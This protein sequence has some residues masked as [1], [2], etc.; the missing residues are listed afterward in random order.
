MLV[1]AAAWIVLI[2]VSFFIGSA[3]MSLSDLSSFPLV[4][5]RFVLATWMG[6]ITLA[7]GLMTVSLAL[8]LV[9]TVTALT[10]L[11]L[12][13]GA[14]LVPKARRTLREAIQSVRP[15]SVLG[16]T[17]LLLGTAFYTSQE[18]TWSDT[19]LY[20]AGAIA[21]LSQSGT[22]RGIALLEFRYGFTSAWFSLAAAFNTGPLYGRMEAL[23]GGYALLLAS[24]HFV[25]SAGRIAAGHSRLPDWFAATA[26]LTCL[27]WLVRLGLSISPSPDVPVIIVVIVVT[28]SILSLSTDEAK[29]LPE[30]PSRLFP[31]HAVPVLMAAGA[32]SLKPTAAPLLLVAVLFYVWSC[33]LT[34]QFVAL[35][36]LAALL[37]L[38]TLVVSLTTSGCPLFPSP[39]LCTHLPWSLGSQVAATDQTDG[40][41]FLRW[42]GPPPSYGD[43]FNW[44]GHWARSE[45]LGTLYIAYML[46]SS[47]VVAVVARF[48]RI[49]GAPWLIL[50]GLAG[51]A[52]VL[53]LSPTYRFLLGYV[54]VPPAYLAALL[55]TRFKLHPVV[56]VL[57][58]LV[59]I[60]SFV[61]VTVVDQ[62]SNAWT[63]SAVAYAAILPAGAL[64]LGVALLLPS[65]RSRSNHGA[66][67]RPWLAYAVCGIVVG[68]MFMTANRSS[69]SSVALLSPPTLH[70]PPK[71]ALIEHS[72]ND[73][74]YVSPPSDELCWA[75]IPCTVEPMPPDLH[76]LNPQQGISG[77]LAKR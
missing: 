8:P 11:A 20:H 28:W 77:G 50:I 5:D 12:L 70:S 15:W 52:Y 35:A 31:P 37:V 29:H 22:V 53:A 24:M 69:P 33:R 3:V 21:W 40:R 13:I 32:F 49:R 25:V 7:I 14:A 72:V 54:I 41:D 30:R 60:V 63:R 51:V 36:G 2:A 1:L 34:L 48:I 59:A 9:P 43:S 46:V 68:G 62:H 26:Y 61:T 42:T 10:T 66:L 74:Y 38:P 71:N 57:P 76:L 45:P 6:S 67:P 73:V 55:C 18:V 16:F 47:V 23:T 17:A 4:S 39:I 44:I 75:V 64:S 65:F 58:M 56:L 19:G 27:T